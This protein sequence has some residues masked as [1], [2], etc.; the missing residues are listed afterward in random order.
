MLIENKKTSKKDIQESGYYRL[1]GNRRMA[2]LFQS[3]HS[4]VISNGTE[5][6]HYIKKHSPYKVYETRYSNVSLKTGKPVKKPQKIDG[7]TPTLN[8]IFEKY[9][10]GENCFFPKIRISKDELLDYGIDLKSKNH[11]ELDGVWIINDKIRVTEIK[12]GS[13]FDTKKSDGEINMFKMLKK[14]F[15]NIEHQ[16]NFVL[17]NLKD[18]NDNS[19]KSL[20][21]SKYIT[22]GK[23]FSEEIGL[24]FDKINSE[25]SKDCPKNEKW[26]IEEMKK[27]IKEYDETNN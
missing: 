16:M 26:V 18:I 24:P 13:D 12:D 9:N 11:I 7:T 22:N 3:G 17:W 15:Q 5:L 1:V 8:T 19:V 25:R 23:T 27:I 14:V 4:C 20:E 10:K 2:S 6:E 21:A